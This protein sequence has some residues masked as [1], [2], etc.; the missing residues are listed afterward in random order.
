MSG[1]HDSPKAPFRF[2]AHRPRHA[3]RCW[4]GLVGA[5]VALTSCA[6]DAL[7]GLN[8]GPGRTFSIRVGE[9][10]AL[11]L[12]SIGPGEYTAPPQLSTG[13]IQFIDAALVGPAVPA[14]ETQLFRFRGAAPGTAVITFQHTG[15]SATIVDTVAVR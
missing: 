11:R 1:I 10:L 3:L 4:A 13:A 15:S 6:P 7:T 8:A 2:I 12:Q 14:G 5:L 9:Y